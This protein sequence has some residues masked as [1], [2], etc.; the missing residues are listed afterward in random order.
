MAGIKAGT[1]VDSGFLEDRHSLFHFFLPSFFFPLKI[2]LDSE[3]KYKQWEQQW[4]RE[5]QAPQ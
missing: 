1:P 4:K 2:L 3:R 5:K